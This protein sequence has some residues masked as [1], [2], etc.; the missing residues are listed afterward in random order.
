MA[1]ILGI[2]EAEAANLKELVSSGA[3][4]IDAEVEEEAI[5]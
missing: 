5:F 2:D 1:S 3:V 4:K